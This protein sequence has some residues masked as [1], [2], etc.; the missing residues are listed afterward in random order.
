[1]EKIK[2]RFLDIE[3]KNIFS[4]INSIHGHI[5]IESKQM[6]GILVIIDLNI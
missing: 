3:G 2:E 5:D 4:R 6:D 1:M